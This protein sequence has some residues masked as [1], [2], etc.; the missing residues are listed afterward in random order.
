MPFSVED[1]ILMKNLY[2]LKGYTATK[3]NEEFPSKGWVRY[4]LY[5]LL[6]RV[7]DTGTAD[8]RAGI[9]RPRSARTDENTDQWQTWLHARVKA[10]GRRFEHLL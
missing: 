9:G 4:S 7:K 3:L 1:R 2:F 6:K 10:K 5:R 8:R